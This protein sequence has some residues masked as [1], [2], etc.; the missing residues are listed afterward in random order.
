M[1]LHAEVGIVRTTI[2]AVAERAGV[3][4]QT[5]SSHF[6]DEMA[7]VSACQAHWIA[8]NPFPDIEAWARI[9]DPAARL[10]YGLDE[11]Y[12]YLDGTDDMIGGLLRDAEV[13]ELVSFGVAPYHVY[14]AHAVDILADGWRNPARSRAAIGLALSFYTWRT[15]VRGQS[16]HRGA[17]V[18]LMVD[19]VRAATAT[20]YRGRR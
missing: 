20:D 1:A 2:S 4:R 7:I 15:L 9:S 6:A 16:L 18:D 11:W 10:R 5:V 19:L 17:A 13:S 14:I 8:A 3:Q 12:G